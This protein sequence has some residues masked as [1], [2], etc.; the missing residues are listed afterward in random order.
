M[1]TVI[2]KDSGNFEAI[3]GFPKEYTMLNY[4]PLLREAT[5][6]KHFVFDIRKLQPKCYSFPYHFHHNAE[7]LMVILSGEVSLR[8]EKGIEILSQGDI[9]FFEIGK[10]GA[11]QFYNHTDVEC[12]YLDLRST[13]GFDVSEYPDSNKIGYPP[14]KE[15]LNSSVKLDYFK[16]EEDAGKYWK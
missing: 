13:F 11:H 15:F 8:T 10:N 14:F 3:E 7:E 1:P 6:S 12:T 4:V 2:K 9:V 16:G 5:G